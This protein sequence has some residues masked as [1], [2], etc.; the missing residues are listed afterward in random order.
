MI[1]FEPVPGS[2]PWQSSSLAAVAG[3]DDFARQYAGAR[4]E[5]GLYRVHDARSGAIA[6]QSIPVAFPDFIGYTAVFGQDWLGRQFGF[7]PDTEVDGAPQVLLFEFST[8][9][10]LSLPFNLDSFHQAYDDIREPA[11]AVGLFEQWRAAHPETLPLASDRCI[12]FR[13]PLFLD[14]D[15]DIAN[16]EESDLDVYLSVTA[17]VWD[18]VRDL[19]EGTPITG[20]TG[21]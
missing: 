2:Q 8:G 7:S 9:S 15:E 5:G 16:L 4:T 17:Q 19:P 1:S 12:G 14:G 18:Q 3:Y 21:S 6:V 13:Q 10:V 11:F 20:V